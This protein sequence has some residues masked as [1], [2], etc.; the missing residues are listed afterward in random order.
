MNNIEKIARLIAR[1]LGHN[2]ETGMEWQRYICAAELIN[3]EFQP[4]LRP[5]PPDHPVLIGE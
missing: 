5:K 2:D 1:R 3:E 4:R